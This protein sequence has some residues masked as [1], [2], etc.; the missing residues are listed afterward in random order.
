MSPQSVTGPR[1][2]S[3]GFRRTRAAPGLRAPAPAESLKA[4]PYK[5]SDYFASFSR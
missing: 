4:L 3:P 1:F 2:L 5:D